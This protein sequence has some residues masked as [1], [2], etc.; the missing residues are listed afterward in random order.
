[1]PVR[2]VSLNSHRDFQLESGLWLVGRNVSCE[3]RIESSRVSRLHCCLL[4]SRDELMV[5][6]LCSTNGTW[7]SGQRLQAAAKLRH[8]D[9]FGIAHLRY[10]LEISVETVQGGTEIS[11]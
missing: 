8:G 11:T 5:R 10:R 6:D 2:L 4:V 9:E 3:V 1:M 7:V